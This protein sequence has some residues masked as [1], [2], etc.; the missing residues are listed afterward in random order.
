MAAKLLPFQV[1]LRL[2]E[3]IHAKCLE[4][5]LAHKMLINLTFL[6]DCCGPL[7]NMKCLKNEERLGCAKIAC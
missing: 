6:L 5:L 4:Q 3:L 2:N 1:V 7:E